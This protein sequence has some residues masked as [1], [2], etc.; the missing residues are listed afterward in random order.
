MGVLSWLR[1]KRKRELTQAE[2]KRLVELGCPGGSDLDKLRWLLGWIFRNSPYSH[3]TLIARARR[4]GIRPDRADRLLSGDVAFGF[5]WDLIEGMLEDCGAPS[6]GIEL[7][8]DL[9]HDFPRA[10]PPRPAP[11]AVDRRGTGT[12]A[13]AR[14]RSDN[15]TGQNCSVLLTDVVGFGAPTRTDQDR[16]IIREVMYRIVRDAFTAA[17]ISR[18]D[19]RHE[20]R[21]DGI[22]IVIS[23]DVPTKQIVHP[24]VTHIIADL[25]RY[26]AGA[27]D[28]ARFALRIALHVG[29]VESDAE[30]VNGQVIIDAAR[31]IDATA[32]KQ[33]LARAGPE[34]C[35]G[36]I[37]S[38]FVY[39][40]TIK[41]HPD[42]LD[43]AKYQR[44]SGRGKGRRFTAWIHLAPDDPRE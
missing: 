22:L 5:R 37:A 12:R 17:G 2:V 8:H 32:F 36:F 15:W 28:G 1:N 44:I 42:L 3:K 21:G 38:D 7:A 23:P 41:Q 18:D 10:S 13:P 40:N 9:F 4:R 24:L 25:S 16:K 19:Y 39:D 29:P 35:L 31:L 26:N 33:R 34:I 27:G 14:T 43:P 11:P 20:D 6:A 30:G